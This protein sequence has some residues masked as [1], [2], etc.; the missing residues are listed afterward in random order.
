MSNCDERT[1]SSYVYKMADVNLDGNEVAPVKGD[2]C[3]FCGRKVSVSVACR[4][5][6]ITFHEGCLKVHFKQAHGKPKSAS[7]MSAAASETHTGLIDDKLN[8][9]LLKC[10]KISEENRLLKEELSA[11]RQVM[12]Q[13][14]EKPCATCAVHGAWSRAL[15]EPADSMDISEAPAPDKSV[16]I[17]R[18]K[19]NNKVKPSMG[20]PENPA[21][22]QQAQQPDKNIEV[23]QN[24]KGN[25]Q[26]ITYDSADSAADNDKWILAK[27]KPR[28]SRPM[29]IGTADSVIDGSIRVANKRAHFHVYW[30]HPSTTV[31]NLNAHINSMSVTDFEI[32][33]LDSRR[34]SEYASFRVSVPFNFL[35]VMK[36]PVKWP[37]GA[38]VRRFLFRGAS[39]SRAT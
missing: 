39:S 17:K 4:I 12:L 21:A 5:C 9:L 36:D 3:D 20:N 37:M 30:L 10:D 8:M 32:V 15:D 26:P 24:N 35:D 13:R 6:S 34:A 23:L 11:L 29:V 1:N 27:R 22:M 2:M 7:G 33:K 25:Q 14:A 19:G 38:A 31:E 18:K 28:R 16:D